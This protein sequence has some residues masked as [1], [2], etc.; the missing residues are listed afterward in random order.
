MV[1][2]CSWP[3]PRSLADTLTMPLASMSKVTSTCGT[4]RGA[5]AMPV[6]SK[7]PSCLLCCAI[8]RS[9]WKTWMSTLGWL[10]SAVENTSERLVGIAVLRSMSLVNR[11]PLV[12]M[13][14]RQ[15]GDVDEQDVL[16]L[17]LEDTG[18]QARAH[19]DDLVGVDA[20]VGLLATGELL[21]QRGHGGH[22]G[23]AADEDHVVDVGQR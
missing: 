5:G 3:V 9:P 23:R 12:S 22:A 11:P 4:P 18:L 6:S 19:G 21:D 13:P 15:R 20:L 1:I 17:A 2:F 8:S 7:V 10:S 14:R 16:A